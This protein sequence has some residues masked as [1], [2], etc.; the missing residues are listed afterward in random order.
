[1]VL[2][3]VTLPFTVCAF[4]AREQIS[5]KRRRENLYLKRKSTFISGGIV[6]VEL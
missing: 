4:E 5:K 1:L 3:S 2:A 6:W